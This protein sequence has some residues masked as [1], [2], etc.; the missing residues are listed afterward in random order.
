MSLTATPLHL[1]H[2]HDK[3]RVAWSRVNKQAGCEGDGGSGM[4]T[5]RCLIA[6]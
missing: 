3:L 2:M 6:H 1:L 5:C 4:E